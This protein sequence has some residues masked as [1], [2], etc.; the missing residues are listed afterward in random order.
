MLDPITFTTT[1]L[2]L[3]NF[4]QELI[5]VGQSIKRSIEKVRDLFSSES[6]D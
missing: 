1:L 2:T 5:E 3:G 6:I 4:I